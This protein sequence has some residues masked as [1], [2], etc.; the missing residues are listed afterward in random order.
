MRLDRFLNNKTQLGQKKVRKLIASQS[1]KA[2]GEIV[3]DGNYLINQFTKI[4]LNNKLLQSQTAHY[5][6][7]NKPKGYVSATIDS[8]HKTV[9]DLILE[10]YKTQLHLGGRLD[11]NTTGLLLLTND[12]RWSRKITEPTEKKPKTYRV[13]T[14]DV[15]TK[16]YVDQFNHG[17]FLEREQLTTQAAQLEII[18]TRQARLTI[19][20]GRYHQVKRMFGFFDNKVTDLHRESM[21]SILLDSSLSPGAYRQLTQREIDSIN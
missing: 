17:I 1:V 5:L 15:I 18:N 8:K 9:L 12:G 14:Q 20:E 3:I 2:N 7:L 11:F 13:T 16:D 6:M 21:G 19:Y 10:S 4:E